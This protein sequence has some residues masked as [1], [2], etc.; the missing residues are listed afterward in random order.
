MRRRTPREKLIIKA[1]NDLFEEVRKQTN[2]QYCAAGLALSRHWGWGTTRIDRLFEL[3][4]DVWQECGES[5]E[6]SM[7]KMLEDETG[8]ELILWDNGKSWHD[9]DFLNGKWNDS[10]LKDDMKW[11]YMRQHQKQWAGTTIQASI[12]LALHRRE[13]FGPERI[14]RLMDQMHEI[15]DELHMKEIPLMNTLLKE[16]GINI[17]RTLKIHRDGQE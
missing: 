13:G 11:L 1:E 4:T 10:V 15:E 6:L 17:V 3:S 2:I 8:I 9:C 5:L 16:T 7:L 12:Y 14:K